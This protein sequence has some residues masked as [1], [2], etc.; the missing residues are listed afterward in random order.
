[1]DAKKNIRPKRGEI[2]G[3]WKRHLTQNFTIYT[4]H[5]GLSETCS[6]KRRAEKCIKNFNWHTRRK[7]TTWKT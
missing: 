2:T 1:M 3:R 7:D 6:T 5:Q 4:L